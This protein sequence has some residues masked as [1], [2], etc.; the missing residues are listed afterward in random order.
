MLTLALVL[1]SM[2]VGAVHTMAPDHWVP[3]AALARSERWTAVRTAT[4]TALCGLGHV[5]VSVALGLAA[6][7]FGL[8]VVERFGRRLEGLGG[9]FLIA[10]GVIY[11]L[12]GLHRAV[13]SRWHVHPHS[14]VHWHT[15]GREPHVH[16][17]ERRLTP[18]ALFVLFS[19]DP[20][21]AVIPLMFAVAPLGAIR[22]A[23]VVIAYELATI[24]TMIALVLPARAAAAKAIAGGWADRYGHAIAGGLIAL[25]G[26]VVVGLGT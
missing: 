3:F 5:T 25:I 13:W 20:C 11:A 10:F 17:G 23:A 22:T 18:W 7:L 1:T 21:V 9:V 8:E 24:A 12:W 16:V 2:A 4:V 19:A 26:V 15:H 6:A 14:H